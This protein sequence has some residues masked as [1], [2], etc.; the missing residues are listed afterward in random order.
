MSD[1]FRALLEAAVQHHATSERG[2]PLNPHHLAVVMEASLKSGAGGFNREIL[3]LALRLACRERDAL[4]SA[5]EAAVEAAMR[6]PNPC[7]VCAATYG[8][9]RAALA[10][11]EK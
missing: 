5:C 8:Q 4:R 9:L 7:A 11:E 10:L 2:E 3:W 6:N 1:S